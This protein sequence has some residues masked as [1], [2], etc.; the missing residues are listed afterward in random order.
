MTRPRSRV[1][2][3]IGDRALAAHGVRALLEP[4][5][6]I[7]VLGIATTPPDVVAATRRLCPDILVLGDQLLCAN[8]E[9]SLVR[10]LRATRPA[11]EIV[12]LEGVDPRRA[13][14]ALEAGAAGAVP[15]TSEAGELLDALRSVRDG[16]TVTLES[17]DPDSVNSGAD[18]NP[19]PIGHNLSPRE[20]EILR[21]LAEGTTTAAIAANLFLS[22]NTVRNHVQHILAK[23]GVHSRVAA[24]V[25]AHREGLVGGS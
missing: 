14:A 3:L 11:T 23:L 2:V 25:V 1:R 9:E 16:A 10:Q 12:V 18:D 22:P 8:G 21:Q 24:V 17:V 4:H 5:R 6:E 13:R 7:E 20:R 19:R 15:P